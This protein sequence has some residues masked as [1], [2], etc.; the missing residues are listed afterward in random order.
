MLSERTLITGLRDEL[1]SIEFKP[2]ASCAAI[3]FAD[4]IAFFNRRRTE[5]CSKI[6]GPL[7]T[8]PPYLTMATSRLEHDGI[9]ATDFYGDDAR[10]PAPKGDDPTAQ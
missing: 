5:K 7:P 1:R 2:R 3:Q 4:F 6:G 8:L 10:I 9:V